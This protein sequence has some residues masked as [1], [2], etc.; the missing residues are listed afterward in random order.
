MSLETHFEGQAE[1]IP[2]PTASQRL[3]MSIIYQ[4]FNLIPNLTMCEKTR[5][6][7]VQAADE[8]RQPLETIEKIGVD[9]DPSS[10]CGDL[11]VAQQQIVEIATGRIRDIPAGE[12]VRCQWGV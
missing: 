5:F 12:G 11:P 8:Y 4:E 7:L 10:R 1:Q 3:G 6:G 9:I 2:S